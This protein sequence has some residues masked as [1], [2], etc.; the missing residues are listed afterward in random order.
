[1]RPIAG[2]W[3]GSVDLIVIADI[4]RYDF[5]FGD[6]QFQGDAVAEADRYAMQTRQLP[7]QRVQPQRRM[8]GIC[9]QQ[10]ERLDILIPRVRVESKEARGA[11]VVLLGEYQLPHH[12]SR[13]FGK[14]LDVLFDGFL[15]EATGVQIRL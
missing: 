2:E 11:P 10:F 3:P 14:T 8:V 13:Q 12:L 15:D 4:D 7:L 5:G 9:L 6:Q 1:M